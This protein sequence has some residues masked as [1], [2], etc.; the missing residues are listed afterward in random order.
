[1]ESERDFFKRLAASEMEGVGMAFANSHKQE[2]SD[3]CQALHALFQA[4]VDAGFTEAQALQLT[5]SSISSK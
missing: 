1:M 5:C 2:I 3:A 4:L